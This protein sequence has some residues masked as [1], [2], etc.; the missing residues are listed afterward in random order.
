MRMTTRIEDEDNL[1]TALAE[2]AATDVIGYTTRT[3][4]TIYHVLGTGS[5]RADGR[6]LTELMDLDMGCGR[7]DTI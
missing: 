1:S 4:A 3:E 7:S 6:W 5:S 2:A